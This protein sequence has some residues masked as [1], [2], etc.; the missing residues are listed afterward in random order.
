[1]TVWMGSD[2]PIFGDQAQLEPE[3]A[4]VSH[5]ATI[6]SRST[7]PEMIVLSLLH[8]NCLVGAGWPPKLAR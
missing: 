2:G 8:S 5:P 6:Q 4:G 7:G 3:A 1:M